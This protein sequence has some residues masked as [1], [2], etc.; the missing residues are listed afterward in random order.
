M[1]TLIF[2]AL[3]GICTLSLHAQP[4][5]T[6]KKSDTLQSRIFD[7][8]H[9]PKY[10]NA[11]DSISKYD[12]HRHN[13]QGL[14]EL[15]GNLRGSTLQQMGDPLNY[16]SISIFNSLASQL[17]ISMN[18]I[19]INDHF[20][21]SGNLFAMNPE[22]IHKAHVYIGSDASIL[23][24]SSGPYVYLQENMYSASKPFSRLWYIQGGYDLIGTE[25]VLTQN[26]DTNLNI[27]G[28]F[29]RLSSG[30]MLSNA[31]SDI[32]NTRLG[33]RQSLSHDMQH[34][35]QW[36]FSNH[37]SYQ[38]G[39]VIGEYQNPISA[40]VMYQN[41]F[42]RRYSHQLHYNLTARDLVLNQDVLLI[43]AYYQ[44]EL[45]ET[46]GV[47][48][49]IEIDSSRL[50]FSP[51]NGYGVQVRH[52]IPSIISS[53]SLMNEIGIRHG[54]YALFNR[55]RDDA[56]MLHAYTYGTY[57][58]D[59]DNI[60]RFGLRFTHS[61]YGQFLNPG[62]SFTSRFSK[63]LSLKVDVSR[64]SMLPSIIQQTIMGSNAIEQ[65]QL[66]FLSMDYAIESFS[67]SIQP[68]YRNIQSP[69]LYAIEYDTSNILP[70]FLNVN[71]L[72]QSSLTSFGLYVQSNVMQGPFS[73]QASMQYVNADNS[74]RFTPR[75]QAR[76]NAEYSLFFGAST[77]TFGLTGRIIDQQMTMRYIPYISNFAHDSMQSI[78]AFAWNGLDIHVSAILGNARIRASVMNLLSAT[79]MDIAGY[80][81]HD[82]IIRLSLNWS[83]FD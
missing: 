40:N 21:N 35:I 20:A 12:F 11:H 59:D 24:G 55:Y 41:Y 57:T 64:T 81:I 36:L 33:L 78:D 2:I 62:I 45:L 29:R 48:P 4:D 76:I 70:Q 10:A 61:N 82:N 9:A 58:L 16:S 72:N 71:G 5:T 39:G 46:R 69:Q 1:K 6:T 3:F 68:F 30:G 22:S 44:D 26:V 73:M 38:N 77:V 80:P 66:A 17:S 67:L 14:G 32:W 60:L 37:G 42:Q 13:Y 52:E 54:R 53:F 18:G 50:V 63:D 25:G 28:S 19:P 43:S 65:H 34:S 49:F 56:F 31:G 15:I 74:Y 23:G 8:M 7:H 83:F 75:L 79:L 27:H 47:N 51:S